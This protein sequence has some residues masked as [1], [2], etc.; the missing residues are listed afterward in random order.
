M[1]RTWLTS[2][3]PQYKVVF[4]DL[5]AKKGA[6]VYH[7]SAGQDRTGVATA[8]VLS[9]LGVPRDLI[10]ADYHL[11]TQYRRPENEMPKLDAAAYPNNPVAAYYRKAQMSPNGLKPQPLYDKSGAARLSATFDE[12]DTRWGSVENYLDKVL[13]VDA[14]DIAALRDRKS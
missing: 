5:L 11:S 9:A 6:V 3:A 12:I 10:L 14:S 1:Y 2:L 4:D 8:L 13:G 7:C